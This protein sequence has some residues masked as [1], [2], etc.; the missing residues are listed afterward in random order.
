MILTHCMSQLM[1]CYAAHLV[2]LIKWTIK[3]FHDPTGTAVANT[4]TDT[5]LQ[6]LKPTGDDTNNTAVANRRVSNIQYVSISIQVD[7][8]SVTGEQDIT[9][10]LNTVMRLPMENKTIKDGHVNDIE[11]HTFQ[12]DDDIHTYTVGEWAAITEQTGQPK[13][14]CSLKAASYGYT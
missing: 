8:S 2:D 14:A 12:G 4:V 3:L 6:V 13:E 1:D 5:N 11:V 10:E 9:V 7:L